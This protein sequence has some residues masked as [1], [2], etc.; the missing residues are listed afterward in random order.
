[1]TPEEIA[2]KELEL[3]KKEE[4]LLLK[5]KAILE[6]Q[7]LPDDEKINA[8][9]QAKLDESLKEIKSK[10]D[11]AYEKRDEALKK[12]KEFEQKEREAEIKRLEEA[13]KH[14]EVYDIKL[15]ELEAEKNTL[16]KR[17]V[18]LTRDIDLRSELGAYT[19][20]N[21]KALKSAFREIADELVRNEQE[22]WVHKS[23]VTVKEYVKAFCESEENAFLIKQPTSSGAGSGVIK[24]SAGKENQK[25]S[26]FD[27]SQEEVMKMAAAGHFNK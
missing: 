19:F 23:G 11:S 9:V 21:D 6:A 24:P 15:A 27:M 3:A 2:A 26:L 13:G 18:E 7:K 25:K 17:N 5:E 16:A 20:K 14:K 4:A 12:I 8:A 1:M 10:L 22:I